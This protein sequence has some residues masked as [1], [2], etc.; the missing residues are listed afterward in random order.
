MI[1]MTKNIVSREELVTLTQK[2][3]G[4]VTIGHAENMLRRK[5][6][7]YVKLQKVQPNKNVKTER[8]QVDGSI[9]LLNQKNFIINI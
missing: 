1:R 3:V 9:L 2:Y 6:K 4:S 7:Q 8:K 5:Q